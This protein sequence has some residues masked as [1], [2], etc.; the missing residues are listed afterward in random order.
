MRNTNGFIKILISNDG[1][2]E[3]LGMRAAGPQASAFI[4]S[5]AYLINSDIPL[6]KAIQSI[7]PHP[8]VTEGIQECLRVFYDQSI[9]KPR[10]F[11]SLITINE[12]APEEVKTENSDKEF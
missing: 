12:W 3:I 4:V 5:I 1:K 2:D 9:Y 11:P 8:S 10:A 7:H 6:Y